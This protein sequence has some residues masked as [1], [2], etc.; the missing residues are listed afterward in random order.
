MINLFF[1][2]FGEV[3]GAN[4]MNKLEGEIALAI[5]KIMDQ[6][7]KVLIGFIAEVGCKPSEIRQVITRMPDGRVMWYLEQIPE[8]KDI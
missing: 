4:R 1:A 7:G 3:R 5:D 2:N 6:R 8:I